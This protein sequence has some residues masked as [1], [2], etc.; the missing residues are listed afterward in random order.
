MSTAPIATTED[1]PESRILDA[2]LVQFERVGVKKSTIED[3]ARIAGVDRVTVYRRVGSRDDLVRAV[4]TREVTTLLAELERLASRHTDIAD[5]IADTLVTVMRAW[6]TNAV[7]QR[8]MTLEP[9]RLLPQLSTE[10][11][12]TF[13]MAVVATTAAMQSVAERGLIPRHPDV[14]MRAEIICRIVQSLLLSPSP[15]VPIESDVKLDAFARR[16]L[17][18]IVA[19]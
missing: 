6:R 10:G 4:F 9:E 18:P 2:A 12:A 14:E 17:T 1:G 13:T 3:I 11:S 19:N 8:M 7:V 16:Y 15:R 5:L